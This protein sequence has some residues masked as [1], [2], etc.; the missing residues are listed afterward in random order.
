MIISQSVVNSWNS[1]TE[2][3]RSLNDEELAELLAANNYRDA[4]YPRRANGFIP[5]EE[6]IASQLLREVI[7]DTQI[8]RQREYDEAQDRFWAESLLEW[9]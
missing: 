8:E 9:D 1:Y 6:E 2:I 5:Q 7:E 4:S 3:V